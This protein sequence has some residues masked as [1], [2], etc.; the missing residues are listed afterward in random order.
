MKR[1]EALETL[2]N[3]KTGST[4]AENVLNEPYR[5]PAWEV[6][7]GPKMNKDK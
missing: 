3:T 7:F 5:P 1:Y 6:G 4:L 2:F